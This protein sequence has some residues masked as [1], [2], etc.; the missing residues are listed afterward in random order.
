MYFASDTGNRGRLLQIK[1]LN[2]PRD[3]RDREFESHRGSSIHADVFS[4][5]QSF[6]SIFIYF[7]NNVAPVNNVFCFGHRK[8]RPPAANLI[9]QPSPQ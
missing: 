8:Q 9:P 7:N 1:T 6:S 2:R 5:L 3:R 4:A